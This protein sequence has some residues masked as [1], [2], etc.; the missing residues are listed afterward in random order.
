[1]LP[2]NIVYTTIKTECMVV[3]L[4][5]SRVNFQTSAWLSGGALTFMD[6]FTYLGDAINKERTDDDDIYK[7]TTKVTLW[8]HAA[9]EILLQHKGEIGVIQEPLLL[10][11][12]QLTVV[13][14]LGCLHELS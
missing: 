9:E 7:E 14:I 3:L 1:M 6:R 5:Y 4:L 2:H 10:F 12:M 8:H 13:A 11:L